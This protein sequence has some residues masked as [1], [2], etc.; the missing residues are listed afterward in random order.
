MMEIYLKPGEAVRRMGADVSF[1]PFGTVLFSGEWGGMP[2]ILPRGDWKFSRPPKTQEEG[3]KTRARDK[4]K[5]DGG[6]KGKGDFA[7]SGTFRM[8]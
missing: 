1:F 3:C 2:S 4:W 8:G 5:S 6:E 7:S